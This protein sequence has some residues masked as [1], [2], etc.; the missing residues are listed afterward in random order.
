MRS[1]ARCLSLSSSYNQGPLSCIAIVFNVC[2][3]QAKIHQRRL[4]PGAEYCHDEVDDQLAK[5]QRN[6]LELINKL[7]AGMGQAKQ[8]F[9]Q[10][11]K[12]LLELED[13]INKKA[14]SV[15]I[16]EVKCGT[17]RKSINI[18]CY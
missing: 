14:N 5:E 17:I 1:T 10:L 12:T 11:Q 16:D 2:S 13:E 9:G 7:E 3:P 8:C 18:N 6:L 4:R 15:Y